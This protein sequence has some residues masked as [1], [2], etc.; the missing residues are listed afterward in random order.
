[1]TKKLELTKL[2]A[3]T[4]GNAVVDTNIV[5]TTFNKHNLQQNLK[6]PIKNQT[7]SIGGGALNA[8][9]TLTKLRFQTYPI[10]P[11]G[12]DHHGAFVSAQVKEK[13]METKALVQKSTHSH[14]STIISVPDQEEPLVFSYKNPELFLAPKDIPATLINQSSLLYIASFEPENIPA[15]NTALE[16]APKDCTI[17]FNPHPQMIEH[18]TAQFELFMEKSHI[19][20]MN[21]YEAELY[22]KKKNEPWN[23]HTFFK[24]V[25]ATK[26]KTIVLT[27][28]RNGVHI[29]HEGHLYSHPSIT[30]SPINTVGAG[31]AFNACFSGLLTLG[32]DIKT[33]ILYSLFNSG[34]VIKHHNTQTGILSI[35]ELKTH[36][37][38]FEQLSAKAMRHNFIF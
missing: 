7:I 23:L 16:S 20:F 10:C 31:D 17:A 25:C 21:Q 34:S 32:H 29:L 33:A 2:Y 26:N 38:S 11:V 12:N 18:K 14:Q 15:I 8:A 22:M 28:G 6:H 19:V 36:S 3:L 13:K 5:S 27:L 4:I 24:L 9:A 35:E 1:M 37:V 30:N